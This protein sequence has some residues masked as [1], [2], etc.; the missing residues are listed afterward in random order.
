MG[1]VSDQLWKELGTPQCKP[2]PIVFPPP[3][4]L[5]KQRNKAWT[6]YNKLM[7][8]RDNL[9]NK[10]WACERQ[11]SKLQEKREGMWKDCQEMEDKVGAAK[12]EVDR[13]F[14]A[15]R[16]EQKLAEE[17][18]ERIAVA[19]MGCVEVDMAGAGDSESLGRESLGRGWGRRRSPTP[20]IVPAR[21]EGEEPGA[22]IPIPWDEVDSGADAEEDRVVGNYWEERGGVS[23]S[24]ATDVDPGDILDD[25]V[26][27]EMGAELVEASELGEDDEDGDGSGHKSW[28]EELRAKKRRTAEI[29]AVQRLRRVQ[30]GV[31]SAT[32]EKKK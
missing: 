28:T 20:S 15:E 24:V 12:V 1:D 25:A 11:L 2:P 6:A 18:T 21:N 31:R 30:S 27:T 8:E 3:E 13:L 19:G 4:N 5:H 22:E 7:G 23:P 10:L 26:G 32:F 16:V 14:G 9:S 29:G 17:A